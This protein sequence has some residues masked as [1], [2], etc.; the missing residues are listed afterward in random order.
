MNTKIIMTSSALVLGISGLV[1]TFMPDELLLYLKLPLE[2][3][4]E[5]LLQILGAL[6]FAFGMT[7]WM[8]KD[9]LIGGIYNRPI[10]IGNMTHFIMVA[11]ASFKLLVSGSEYPDFLWVLSGI[12]GLFAVLFGLILFKTPKLGAS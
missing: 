6:Y 9:T 7:N 12:Y 5:L 10:A 11:I 3:N 1:L 4:I 2:K 8:S